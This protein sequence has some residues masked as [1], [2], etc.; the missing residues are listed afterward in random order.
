MRW[1]KF[2]EGED[3]AMIQETFL[4]IIVFARPSFRQ[5]PE[6]RLNDFAW[7]P[8]RAQLGR[9]DAAGIR[10]SLIRSAAELAG[11]LKPLVSLALILA[12]AL[13]TQRSVFA[14]TKP[15]KEVRVPYALGGSTGFFWVAQRSGSFEK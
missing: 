8:A 15:L 7:I 6:S 10:A 2:Y 13:V 1:W 3:T 12:F 11:T 9:D 14:Q 4:R 5:K